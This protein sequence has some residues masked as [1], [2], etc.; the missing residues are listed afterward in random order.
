MVREDFQREYE[1]LKKGNGLG[2]TAARNNKKKTSLVK[3]NY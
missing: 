1:E 3:K 2:R